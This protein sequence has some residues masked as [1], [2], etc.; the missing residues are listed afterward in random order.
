MFDEMIERIQERTIRFLLK[1]V[2]RAEPRPVQRIYPTGPK[3]AQP[4]Q[5]A[6]ENAET[7][8]QKPAEIP[9]NAVQADMNLP[10]AVNVDSL[11]TS[12]DTKYNPATSKKDKKPGPIR[13]P[14]EAD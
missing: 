13:A 10:K 1:C 7:P 12:G 9:Q 11:Q 5:A 2:V 8:A 14:A 4:R 6:S 3:P